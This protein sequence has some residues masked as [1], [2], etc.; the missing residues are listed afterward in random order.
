MGGAEDL[1]TCWDLA[2]DAGIGMR[3]SLSPSF[4]CFPPELQAG[5]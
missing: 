2:E 3:Q 1:Q 5:A 4:C